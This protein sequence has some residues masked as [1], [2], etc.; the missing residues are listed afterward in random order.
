LDVT[1]TARITSNLGVGV[2]P[3]ATAGSINITNSLYINGVDAIQQVYNMVEANLTLSG[4]GIV[5]WSGGIVSWTT[6][7]IAI[8][9]PA[10]FGV[11]G[12]FDIGP[13]TFNLNTGFS[14]YGGWTALYYTPTVG[15]GYGY[16]S[17]SMKSTLYSPGGANQT[18]AQSNS[19]L[20][21]VWTA[22][23]DSLKWLPGPVHIP[24]GG[25]YNSGTGQ[26]SLRVQQ[27]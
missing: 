19:I 1:G 15:A 22:D 23:D 12:F 8:P 2:A 20:I 24:N 4:G 7:V 26:V 21:C 14:G 16:V 18:I 6:R 11:D 13:A 3:I 10:S 27:F 5:T 25:Y 17:G 9:I